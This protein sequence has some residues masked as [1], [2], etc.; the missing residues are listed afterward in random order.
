[1]IVADVRARRPRAPRAV[2]RHALAAGR[3]RAELPDGERRRLLRPVQARDP[4]R[5]RQPRTGC[6]APTHCSPP[7]RTSPRSSATPWRASSWPTCPRQRPS[8]STPLTFLVSAARP[9]A[10]ALPGAGARGGEQAARS[11]WR[12]LREGMS[13]LRHH[14][15][16][17]ANTLMVVGLRRRP[18][19]QLPAD[20]PP[21]GATCWTAARRRSASSRPSSASATWSAPSALA[22]LATRVPKGLAMAI[23]WAIMG[24]EPGRSSPSPRRVA[25]LHPVRG[26]S[27]SPT[28]SRSSPSTPTCRTS[29][30]SNCAAACSG[31]RFTLTQ[32]T[33]ALS[34]L[35]GGALAGVFDVRV[36]FIVAGVL[37]AVPGIV[38]LFVREIR[39][40]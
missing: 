39:D 31:A 16:L 22:T 23:G 27:A 8:A 37:V 38:A 28:P 5:H 19:R 9:H 13:F 21:R 32:G 17:L 10:D 35:V 34:V 29:S 26:R 33:Y 25:G 11:F 6:C 15:G 4:P 3:V 7:A 14:R 20:L 12:E 40:A 18:R 2:R 36:L 24:V 1:M 30:P